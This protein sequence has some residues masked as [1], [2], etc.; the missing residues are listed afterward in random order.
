MPGGGDTTQTL[1]QA[2]GGALAAR[3]AATALRWKRYG[4]WQTVS[5][6]QVAARIDAIAAGLRAVGLREGDVAAVI[7]DNCVE[8][9]MADL[10]IMAAGG[11]SAGLDAHGDAEE[12]VRLLDETRAKVLF[13]VG[14]DQLHKALGVRAR[15]PALT[16]IVIMHEQWDHGEDEAGVLPLSELETRG[17]G[18]G[19]AL[20]TPAPDAPAAIIYTAG[21]T[22]PARGA[23]LSQAALATQAQRAA[24]AL[25]L[26]ADD[27]RVSLTPL[28]QVLERTVGIYASLLSGTIVNFAESPD[29]AFANLT[30]LQPTIIQAS[31]L[32]WAKL[33][34]RIDLALMDVTPLQRWAWRKANARGPFHAVLDR[35]VL[36]PVRARLG[37]ARARLC[38]SS[39]ALLHPD[40]GA[41]FAALGRPLVDLYG[42]AESGGAVSVDGAA[43]PGLETKRDEAGELWLRSATLLTRYANGD[44][45]LTP[46]G[47]WRSGDI[48]QD[49]GGRLQVA[50]RTADTLRQGGAPFEAERALCA[51]PYIADA[52]LHTD[53]D[54]A[55]V[56]R[57]LLDGDAVVKYA[58]DNSLPFTHFQSLCRADGI[59]ALVAALVAEVNR[60]HPATPIARFSLIERALTLRDPEVAPTLAL[61]R[62]LLRDAPDDDTL[63]VDPPAARTTAHV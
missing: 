9:V 63:A 24:D 8:W 12:L 39:G 17:K 25:K 13:V 2:V 5:G 6:N 41:W 15:C 40:A 33:R 34:T 22:A 21:T 44:A 45:P 43:L 3:G 57:I 32:L 29:T 10:G 7:G 26:R 11:L 59:R 55:V 46:D 50:G 14:D 56:A 61:R 1:T 35:L 60:A 30:E 48:G 27:E 19:G 49:D 51:S 23:V 53:R 20:P 31:P 62:Y 37:L 38:L 52:F 58:Q 54:D 36:A 18:D 4:I 28:H 16:R 47:W 42:H